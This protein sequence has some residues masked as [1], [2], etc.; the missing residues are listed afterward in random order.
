MAAKLMRL[1]WLLFLLGLL[2]PIYRL[3]DFLAR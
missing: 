2:L 3:I 1:A